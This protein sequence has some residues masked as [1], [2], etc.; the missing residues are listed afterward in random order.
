MKMVNDLIDINRMDSD[1][2]Q[3]DPE[4]SDIVQ[5]ISEITLSVSEYAQVKNIQISF[6]SNKKHH[7]MAF[8]TFQIERVLLN[9]LSNAVKYTTN[10]GK[11]QVELFIKPDKVYVSVSDNGI[12]IPEAYHHSIFER[13]HK[14]DGRSYIEKKG[15]GM[16][17][18]LVKKLLDRRRRIWFTSKRARKHISYHFGFQTAQGL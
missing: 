15:S 5:A 7:I 18:F 12:G 17:L 11:I 1:F 4:N 6:S 10:R 9:L 13:F 8:D 16:G 14:T 3:I 2:F